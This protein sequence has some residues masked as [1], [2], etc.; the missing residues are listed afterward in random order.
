CGCARAHPPS[1]GREQ[2]VADVGID[3]PEVQQRLRPVRGFHGDRVVHRLVAL[4]GPHPRPPLDD[5][6]E[7]R[8]WPSAERDLDAALAGLHVRT[9]TDERQGIRLLLVAELRA[10]DLELDD[11]A[12]VALAEG[13]EP[14]HPLVAWDLARS[15]PDYL[16]SPG[17]GR[18][19]DASRTPTKTRAGASPRR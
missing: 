8:V 16:L 15:H 4:L 9:D 5:A 3:V 10:D 1:A 18:V 6:R 2:G 14:G 12:L 17:P 7:M 13:V 19:D 11:P